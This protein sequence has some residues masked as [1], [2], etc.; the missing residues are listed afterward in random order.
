[1]KKIFTK[2]LLVPAALFLASGL[3]SAQDQKSILTQPEQAPSFG[4]PT[5]PTTPQAMWSVLFNY[6]LNAITGAPGNAGVISM[7]N[8]MWVTRW[9]TDSMF[10]ID[11]A[12][13]LLERFTVSGLSGTRSLTS[14]GVKIYAGNNTSTV[15]EIDPSSKTISNVVTAPIANCRSLTFDPSVPGGG[16]WASTWTTDITQFNMAG[17]ATNNVLAT[18]HGLTGMY[19]T[20]YDGYSS[21]GPYLWVFDQAYSANA[22]DIVQIN[23]AT[24][25]QTGVYHDVMS[26]IGPTASDT[27]GLAGGIAIRFASPLLTIMGVLQGSPTNR[28][29][30]YELSTTGINEAE[31]QEGFLGVYPNPSTDFINIALKKENNNLENIQIVDLLG[32]VVYETSTHGMNNYI[33]V[34]DLNKGI[35]MVKATNNGVVYTTKFVK[36]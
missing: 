11:M 23:I 35:Y 19:G 3:V 27:S 26:D 14:N 32:N 10:R 1:M 31:N 36:Q 29:F 34:A 24:G 25:M 12:G 4:N 6:D 15:T 13:N 22:S 20:A 9:A 21:G 2:I 28:L 16:F 30:A 18:N 5:N 17:Q 7:G 33:K 8:E